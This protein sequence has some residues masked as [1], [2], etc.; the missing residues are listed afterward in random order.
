MTSARVAASKKLVGKTLNK[1]NPVE[2][3]REIVMAYSELVRIREEEA[4]KRRQIDM[5]KEVRLATI[6][7]QREVLMSY[8]D[9]SF[10]ERADVFRELFRNVD[11]AI[12]RGDTAALKT[13]VQ[14]IVETA[15]SSPF[16]AL[17]DLQQT[18][19]LLKSGDADFSL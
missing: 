1:I 16:A 14:G 4:T 15:K 7:A 2:A 5:E 19:A 6:Q 3:L 12:D 18:R 11:E 9:Q 17:A 8:L 10:S 13:F